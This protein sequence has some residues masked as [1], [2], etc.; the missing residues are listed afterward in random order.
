M[1]WRIL[2][3]ILSFVE[4]SVFMHGG[5]K[6]NVIITLGDKIVLDKVIDFI[7]GA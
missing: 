5:D 3:K 1:I 2:K 4:I 7:P 6:L